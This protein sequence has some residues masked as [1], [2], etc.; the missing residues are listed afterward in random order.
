LL[1]LSAVC[2]RHNIAKA[3]GIEEQ[4]KSVDEPNERIVREVNC[5]QTHCEAT[6]DDPL[7]RRHGGA[8]KGLLPKYHA[9]RKSTFYKGYPAAFSM[10]LP[11]CVLNILTIGLAL[12]AASRATLLII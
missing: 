9:P 11:Y 10:K 8:I 7:A 12:A 6:P 3:R 2:R 5:G 4:L 1:T